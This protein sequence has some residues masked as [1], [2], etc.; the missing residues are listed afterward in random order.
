MKC[1]HVTNSSPTA[2]SWCHALLQDDF[3]FS[4]FLVNH[5]RKSHTEKKQSNCVSGI[6]IST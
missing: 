2:H 3:V 4:L 1:L 6:G 5:L